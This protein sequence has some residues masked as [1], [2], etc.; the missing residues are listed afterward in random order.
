MALS[1]EGRWSDLEQDSFDSSGPGGAHFRAALRTF[2]SPANLTF[3]AVLVLA[4]MAL[5]SWTGAGPKGWQARLCA[6]VSQTAQ[7]CAAAASAKDQ[8][9][10]A[11]VTQLAP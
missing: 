2:C 9:R 4:W 5:I 3:A 6:D 1:L 11:P 8:S 7:A 10:V